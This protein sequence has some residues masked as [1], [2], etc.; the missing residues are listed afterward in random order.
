MC[1]K[2]LLSQFEH[3]SLY[4]QDGHRDISEHLVN[5]VYS[6]TE[7]AE[8]YDC[9]RFIQYLSPNYDAR[10][11]KLLSVYLSVKDLENDRRTI[12]KPAKILRKIIGG[13]SDQA[14]E[15]FAVWYK[16]NVELSLDGMVIKS[17]GTSQDFEK[18]YSMTQA[19]ASDP[20]LGQYRKSLASSCMRADYLDRAGNLDRLP[21]HPAWVYG[22]GDF[23]IVWIENS[24][25]ELLARVVV[26]TRKGR[27]AAAPIY[28]N[29]CIAA[30]MLEGYIAKKQEACEQPNKE[31]WVNARVLKIEV[32]EG[33]FLAP[34]FDQ[35]SDVVDFNCTE[36]LGRCFRIS[37]KSCD[38][39]FETTT[40][41]VGG[42]EYQCEHCGDGCDE[43]DAH[44]HNDCTYC[45]HCF[46]E[47]FFYCEHCNEYEPTDQ[48]NDV[49]GTPLPACDHCINYS[50]NI[51]RTNCNSL[52][53]IDET[54]YCETDDCYFLIDDMGDTWFYSDIDD[55]CYSIEDLADLPIDKQMTHDQAKETGFF[56]IKFVPSK[57]ATHDRILPRLGLVLVDNTFKP[58][59]YVY[60]LK[61]YLELDDDGEVINN[62]LSLLEVA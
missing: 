33:E 43:Y 13:L 46:N 5:I 30:D 6:E 54:I 25:Q 26:C 62:Q 56:N 44:Y 16:D 4:P 28:T 57:P 15:R 55:E 24:K 14:Y 37:G 52:A 18:V 3:S 58:S 29:S 23:E 60:T 8:H 51:V 31:S 48:Y 32:D 11:P 50:E 39:S 45:E 38:F 35:Y 49:V 9:R 2:E 40:G 34:Y 27:Y 36:G 59:R 22:S 10:N 19:K 61:D 12:G 42:H 7:G 53:I 17:G 47:N 21:H 1:F 20:K 41:S